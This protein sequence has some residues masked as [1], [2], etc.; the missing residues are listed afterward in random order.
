ML[1]RMPPD[2]S[3]TDHRPVG[4]ADYPQLRCFC[5]WLMGV[6]LIPKYISSP[7]A[8]KSVLGFHCILLLFETV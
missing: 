1:L 5:L 8:D 3:N 4:F 7:P 2:V 6:P